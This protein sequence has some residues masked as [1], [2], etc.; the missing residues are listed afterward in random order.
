MNPTIS[1]IAMAGISTPKT[2]KIEVHIKKKK[3]QAMKYQEEK[4]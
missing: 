2:L 1:C 3:V 4:Y